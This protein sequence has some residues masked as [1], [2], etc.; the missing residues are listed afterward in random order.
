VHWTTQTQLLTFDWDEN[1][2][3]LEFGVGEVLEDKYD[4]DYQERLTLEVR[5][6]PQWDGDDARLEL[7]YDEAADTLRVKHPIRIRPDHV[8]EQ[9]LDAFSCTLDS[10][11]TTHKA[12]IDVGAN[13]T[14]AIVTTTGDTAVYHTRP[15]FDQF[16]VL[17]ELIAGLQSEL[18]E[19]QYTS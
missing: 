15:E 9:R 19:N 14:L 3:T 8:Q 5:G 16:Q 2:S 7:V 1:T 17:S 6:N 11:N 13:N 12:A 4:F 18:P 10:E